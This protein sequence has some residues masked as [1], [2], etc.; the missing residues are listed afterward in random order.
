MI[1]ET[2]NAVIYFSIYAFLGWLCEDLYC[3]I[4]NKKFIN[5]GFLYGPYCP[6]YGVGALAIL[7]PLLLVSKHPLIVF[8]A[9]IVITSALEYVTSWAMEKLFH[10]RWW[11]YSTY[12]FN[13]NGRI[14]LKNSILFGILCLFVVYVVHPF[15]RDIVEDVS[16]TARVTYAIVFSAIFLIDAAKTIH[17]LMKRKKIL[18]K[19]RAQVQYVWHEFELDQKELSDNFEI[20]LKD[21]RERFE[22]LPELF[23]RVQ[24]L[25]KAR[26]SK[27]FPN[28]TLPEW[29]VEFENFGKKIKK[30]YDDN[31]KE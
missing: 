7:Y 18:E 14:C 1:I 27:A 26:I 11:D 9:G 20:W 23:E 2:I 5:R 21:R 30:L 12:P 6:I 16:W 15:I 8:L 10:A 22:D 29:V 3:G 28:R 24:A 19:M 4:P 17:A 31:G 13:L 25:S